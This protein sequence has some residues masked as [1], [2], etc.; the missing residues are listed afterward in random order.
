MEKIM[1]F[2]VFVH[3]NPYFCAMFIHNTTYV[4]PNDDARDFV[5]WVHQVL[6]P[7][8][9]SEEGLDGGRLV[10]I[11]SHKE[12]DSECFSV[13]FAASTTSLIHHWVIGPGHELESEQQRLF[14]GRVMG[15]ATLMEV[16]D[17]E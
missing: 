7:R 6:L 12:E 14:G 11:L 2:V 17:G 13:Q 4:V 16:I 15:F 3:K 8:V 9:A 1:F 5:I 10:R